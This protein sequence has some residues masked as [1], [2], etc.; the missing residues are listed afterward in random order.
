MNLILDIKSL[1]KSYNN[2]KNIVVKNV[3]LSVEKG[4][5]LVIVGESGSGKNL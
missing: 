2:R 5:I 1:S 3:N 4:K